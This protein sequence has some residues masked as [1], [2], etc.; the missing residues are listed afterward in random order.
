MMLMG[1]IS[2]SELDR[3]SRKPPETLAAYDYYLRGKAE[4]WTGT[5]TVKARQL[6][7]QALA[8]D[9]R[10][11]PA[12]AA[13]ARNYVAAWLNYPSIDGEYQQQ[14]TLDQAFALAGQ[15]VSLDPSLAEAH[16]ELGWTLHW[17]YRRA[18][19][20]AEFDRALEL[21]PNMADGHLAVM[22]IHAGRAA[23]SIEF[24]KR[25]M[26]RDP[27]HLPVY[28]G[29][30]GNAYFLTGDN[31]KSLAMHRLASAR[32]PNIGK[33]HVWHAAAA[34][35]GGLTEEARRAAAEVL[36]LEPDFTISRFLRLIRLAKQSD[37]DLLADGLRKA[38][39]PD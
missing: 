18:E 25:V 10:Y 39:L 33:V 2:K 16:A 5:A 8:S 32:A 13:L 38:G 3:V 11:A 28:F 36:R 17:Q 27:F 7:R 6:F 1:H 35:R 4:R 31:E 26:R 15:A 22:L 14:P 20:L 12:M 29:Y 24:L 30:L 19:A 37:A 21:N 23:E 9:P 34:G